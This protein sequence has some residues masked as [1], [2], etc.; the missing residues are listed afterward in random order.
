MNVFGLDS[1]L[2]M[3]ITDIDDKIIARAQAEKRSPTSIAEQYEQSF[4]SSMKGLGVAAPDY[5]LRVTEHIDEI[6]E[7]I[8]QIRARGFAHTNDRGDVVFNTKA[9]HSTP[10]LSSP[11]ADNI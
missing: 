2:A 6:V 11:M 1:M 7:F 3:G 4:M 5:I 8:N 9:F 10:G